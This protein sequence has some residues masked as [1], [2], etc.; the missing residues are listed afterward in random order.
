MRSR[1]LWL[2]GA[3][4]AAGLA[5]PFFHE[6]RAQAPAAMTASGE[7]DPSTPAGDPRSSEYWRYCA[8]D[9]FLTDCCG[10][11]PSTC[12]PGTEMSSVAWLGTCRNPADGKDY[13]ISYN[14]CCGRT[15]CGK[16][17]VR[18]NEGDKPVYYTNRNNDI[19]WC[20]GTQSAEYNS[21]AAVVVGVAGATGGP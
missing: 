15:H 21:T 5:L 2:L 7:P 13:V 17:F 4:L 6:G 11:E 18:R 10:G 16:C 8:L 9:G 20:M 14:D 19:G 12:P 1:L 3:A